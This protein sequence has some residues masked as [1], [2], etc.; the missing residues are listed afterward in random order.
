MSREAFDRLLRDEPIP[1]GRR[2]CVKGDLEAVA[3]MRA[4][5]DRA[6]GL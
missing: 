4:W 1:P 3:Q 2:P 6:R 5:T